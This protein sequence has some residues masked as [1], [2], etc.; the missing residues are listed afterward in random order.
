MIRHVVFAYDR[1]CNIQYL[2]LALRLLRRRK[3]ITLTIVTLRQFEKDGAQLKENADCLIYQTF[4]HQFHPL[5]Y[6]DDLIK[7][8]DVL[9]RDFHGL[10]FLYDTHDSGSVDSF[11]RFANSQ[12]PRI[13]STPSYD[14][15]RDHNVVLVTTQGFLRDWRYRAYSRER[16]RKD[17]KRTTPVSYCVSHDYDPDHADGEIVKKL[18]HENIRG[19]VRNLLSQYPRVDVDFAWKRNYFRYLKRV[20]ISVCVPGWGEATF[21]HLESLMTGCLALAH[22]SMKEIKLLPHAELLEGEDYVAFN[23]DNLHEKLDFLLA[24][25]D[26]VNEIRAN[27][28]KKFFDG[29]SVETT[30]NELFHLIRGKDAGSVD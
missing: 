30:A 20:W 17:R 21:R 25:P 6:N 8:T 26:V 12:L 11:S 15:M 2:D 1:G 13:K 28:R 24:N 23:T 14:F 7:N 4:P 3:R 22:E 9:F 29:F 18:V 16:R 27:G 19:T 10:K 5:K